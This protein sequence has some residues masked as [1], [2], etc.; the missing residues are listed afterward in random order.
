M[1]GIQQSHIQFVWKEENVYILCEAV[2][3]GMPRK[4]ASQ[5]HKHYYPA[6]QWV[7]NQID[8]QFHWF[9][10]SPNGIDQSEKD[11]AANCFPYTAA[12]G[13]TLWN[14]VCQQINKRSKTTR[15]DQYK[16]QRTLI[17]RALWIWT[18]KLMLENVCSS[19]RTV[20]NR[21]NKHLWAN[22]IRYSITAF[23]L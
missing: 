21:K 18:M 16:A 2:K 12:N 14:I 17:S 7:P 19:I 15:T 4:L 10:K 9:V 20:T 23:Q 6:K 3:L 22:K 13:N 5:S 8:L 11:T 1:H